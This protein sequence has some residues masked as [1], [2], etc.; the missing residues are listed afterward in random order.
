LLRYPPAKMKYFKQILYHLYNEIIIVVRLY[1]PNLKY[2]YL[3]RGF[4]KDTTRIETIRHRIIPFQYR[5]KAF[6]VK[7]ASLQYCFKAF[8]L[9][10]HLIQY[11]IKAIQYRNRLI[12]YRVA[13][14]QVG[15][16]QYNIESNHFNVEM[17]RCMME[18][19]QFNVELLANNIVIR[20]F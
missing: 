1:I 19:N 5:I 4:A 10:N 2:S 3:P 17:P 7:N 15:M 20:P 8:Q 18:I 12:Q 13:Y 14:F 11:R 9:K 16:K 6:L